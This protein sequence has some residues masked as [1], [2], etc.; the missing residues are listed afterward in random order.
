[1]S[2]MSSSLDDLKAEIRTAWSAMEAPPAQDMTFL[3]WEYG[4][5]AVRAF[6][7]IQPVDVDIESPG[8][9]IATPLLDLP[10]QAAAAYLGPYLVALLESFQLEEAWGFPVEIKTRVHTIFTLAWPNFWTDIAAP[11]LSDA[12]VSALGKVTRFVIEH[13]EVFQLSSDETRGL[14]RLLRSIDRR[15]NPSSIR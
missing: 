10:A 6:V 13:S 3:D 14:E 12:C 7:G 1:M 15:L 2:A 5:D 11:N 9:R 8:F 4:E